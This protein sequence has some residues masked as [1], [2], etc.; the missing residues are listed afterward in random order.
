MKK[1]TFLILLTLVGFASVNS[2]SQTIDLGADS[3]EVPDSIYP[4]QEAKIPVNERVLEHYFQRINSF[5]LNPISKKDIVF[6]GNSITEGGG[7]WSKKFK[8]PN[9]KNRGISGDVTDGV[10]LR[11]G[12]IYYFKPK[13]VFILIGINDLFNAEITADYVGKNVIKIANAIKGHCPNTKVY[14]QTIL[15]TAHEFLRKK[16]QE[17]NNVISKGLNTK[18]VALIDLHS[19][20]S[21]DGDLLI[22]DYTHD[23][24]HLNDKGYKLWVTQI[25]DLVE[26]YK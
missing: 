18:S 6:L 9:I 15:P 23:G 17:T 7:D 14:V 24:L 1:M 16:I 2:F 8:I 4:S 26:K 25:E 3:T 5:K 20:F 22:S 12:E 19:V 11:L 21:T 13:V 10:L